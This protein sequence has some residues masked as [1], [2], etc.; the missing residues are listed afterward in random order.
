MVGYSRLIGLDDA[1]TLRRLQTLRR[2][3][4]EPAIREFGGQVVQTGG[5][6]IQWQQ[7]A[8]ATDAMAPAL[9]RGN[10]YLWVAAAHALIGQKITHTAR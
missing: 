2:A 5:E 3:V 8:L 4:I 1:G 9:E 6:S 10:S 7:R